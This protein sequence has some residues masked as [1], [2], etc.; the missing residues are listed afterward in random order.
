MDP[1]RL[2]VYGRTTMS[3]KKPHDKDGSGCTVK[4]RGTSCEE[5]YPGMKL[6][7]RGDTLQCGCEITEEVGISS[8]GTCSI[9]IQELDWDKTKREQYHTIQKS[10]WNEEEWEA[11]PL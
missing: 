9:V 11:V 8:K 1:T 3:K 6:T 10:N 4:Q 5:I 2:A 7:Y